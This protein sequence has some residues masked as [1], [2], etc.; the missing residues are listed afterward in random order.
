[1][2][3]WNMGRN[4]GRS[5]ADNIALLVLTSTGVAL[6]Q[7]LTLLLPPTGAMSPATETPL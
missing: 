5:S 1:M 4:A 6:V 3:G 2:L 7:V